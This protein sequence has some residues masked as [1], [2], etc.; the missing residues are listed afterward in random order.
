MS[1]TSLLIRVA[2]T[3]VALKHSSAYSTPSEYCATEHINRSGHNNNTNN[4]KKLS[5]RREAARWLVLL[6]IFVSR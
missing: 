3:S 2:C 1:L 4:N 5:Y 6:S